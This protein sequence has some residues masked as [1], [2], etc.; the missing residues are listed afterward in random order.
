VEAKKKFLG[1]EGCQKKVKKRRKVDG[2]CEGT[3]KGIEKD[4]KE[5]EKKHRGGER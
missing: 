5:N 2:E 3:N 1:G 4:M